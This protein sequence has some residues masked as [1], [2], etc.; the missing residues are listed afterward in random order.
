M[1]R[2][3]NEALKKLYFKSI[4][5]C[6]K[7]VKIDKWPDL[8]CS[9]LPIDCCVRIN[10][11]SVAIFSHRYLDSDRIN[12][13]T[14]VFLCCLLVHL[15][16][17]IQHRHQSLTNFLNGAS[18]MLNNVFNQLLKTCACQ[19]HRTSFYPLMFYVHAF[20]VALMEHLVMLFSTDYWTVV[21]ASLEY[22]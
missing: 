4:I 14:F 10:G 3:K 13:K 19:Y 20:T 16:I 21:L 18:T 17:I 7:R 8:P 11:Y 12:V 6:F 22:T 9:F 5:K 15:N 2:C 1:I